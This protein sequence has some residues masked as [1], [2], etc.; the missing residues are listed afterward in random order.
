MNAGEFEDGVGGNGARCGEESV[1][2]AEVVE[3]GVG[4][5][6]ALD[7]FADFGVHAISADE[8]VTYSLEAELADGRGGS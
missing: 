7:V 6:G 4:R 8:Y 2:D 5:G 3:G 1:Y